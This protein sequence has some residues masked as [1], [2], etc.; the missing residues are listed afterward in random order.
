MSTSLFR[1]AEEREKDERAQDKRPPV[2]LEDENIIGVVLPN[3]CWDLVNHGVVFVHVS[4]ASPRI[5]TQLRLFHDIERCQRN[6]PK[7]L[8]AGNNH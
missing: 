8:A 2:H 7:Y 6:G 5:N 1:K 3:R 4:P